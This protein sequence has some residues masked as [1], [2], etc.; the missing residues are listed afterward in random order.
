MKKKEDTAV[1]GG[2]IGPPPPHT[3][4]PRSWSLPLVPRVSLYVSLSWKVE[5]FDSDWVVFD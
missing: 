5:K 3:P 1:I 2:R 4:L